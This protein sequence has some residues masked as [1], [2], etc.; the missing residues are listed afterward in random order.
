MIYLSLVTWEPHHH[1]ILWK[2]SHIYDK[3][4][5]RATINHPAVEKY[6]IQC[7]MMSN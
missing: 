2:G 1:F 6:K 7:C 5:H 3:K 4:H